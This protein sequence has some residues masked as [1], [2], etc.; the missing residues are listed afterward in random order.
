MN[1][2][3]IIKLELEGMKHSIM[4]HFASYNETISDAVEKQLDVAIESFDFK[5][6][7]TDATH[8]CIKAAIKNYFTWGAGHRLVGASVKEIL[9]SAQPLK[10]D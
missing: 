2:L 1:D 4:H 7:V 9:D 6:A 5:Q 8:V 3:P 10:E